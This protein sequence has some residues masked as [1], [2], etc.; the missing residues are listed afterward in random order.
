MRETLIGLAGALCT[1]AGRQY[2]SVAPYWKFSTPQGSLS[3]YDVAEAS[4]ITAAQVQAA[5]DAR[6]TRDGKPYY[7]MPTGITAGKGTAGK[8]GKAAQT[9]GKAQAFLSAVQGGTA[10]VPQIGTA[11]KGTAGRLVR[12]K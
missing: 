9:A 1:A 6:Q 12:R 3:L 8:A 4:G 7:R 11:G 10:A 2:A 5:C